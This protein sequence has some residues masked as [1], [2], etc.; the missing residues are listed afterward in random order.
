MGELTDTLVASETRVKA[1][2][3]LASGNEGML[4]ERA[5]FGQCRFRH[6][7]V[8]YAL[9]RREPSNVHPRLQ[10]VLVFGRIEQVIFPGIEVRK[11][12]LLG[13]YVWAFI[14]VEMDADTLLGQPFVVIYSDRIP[15][16]LG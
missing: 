16:F 11:H 8:A 6:D 5:E 12:R 1:A 2:N 13:S 3:G 9:R 10:R 15:A 7:R 14:A 4:S